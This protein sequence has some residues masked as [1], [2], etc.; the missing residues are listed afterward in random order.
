M[1]LGFKRLLKKIWGK[2]KPQNVNIKR[3]NTRKTKKG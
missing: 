1:K 3:R 2:K